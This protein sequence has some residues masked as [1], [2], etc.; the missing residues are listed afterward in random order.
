MLEQILGRLH[1]SASKTDAIRHV[2]DSLVHK[3]Q[4]WQMIGR[5]ARRGMIREIIRIH[6][7]NK[8]LYREVMG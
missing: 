8:Q 7:K 5:E 1:V 6:E 3:R 4:T 2:I